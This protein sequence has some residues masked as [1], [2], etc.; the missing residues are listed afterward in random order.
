MRSE[1]SSGPTSLRAMVATASLLEATGAGGD[2]LSREGTYCYFEKITVGMGSRGAEGKQG[3]LLRSSDR[4]WRPG[5][6]REQ[7]PF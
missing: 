3:D 6:E 4:W 5:Q 1:K 7:Y 2:G